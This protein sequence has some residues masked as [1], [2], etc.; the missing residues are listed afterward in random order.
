MTHLPQATLWKGLTE[1]MGPRLTLTCLAMRRQAQAN[2]PART[3]RPPTP[4]ERDTHQASPFPTGF[5]VSTPELS[6]Q[7]FL[8]ELCLHG[9]M[10]EQLCWAGNV[11][12]CGLT[13]LSTPG[14]SSQGK[15]NAFPLPPFTPGHAQL[16]KANTIHTVV[17]RHLAQAPPWQPRREWNQL[18]S[19][20]W[21]GPGGPLGYLDTSPCSIC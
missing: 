15:G 9:Q 2:R 12:Y 6:T 3:D 5:M 17:L 13:T 20:K 14:P 10:Q 16:L 7:P 11:R 21:S 8:T 4:M 1:R 19:G 18:I